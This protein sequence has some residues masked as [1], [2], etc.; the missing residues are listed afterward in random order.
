MVPNWSP[1]PFVSLKAVSGKQ[2][3]P[4]AALPERTSSTLKS[5]Q[6]EKERRPVCSSSDFV[7]QIFNN[8]HFQHYATGKPTMTFRQ[9][10]FLYRYQRVKYLDECIQVKQ[11]TELFVS[12]TKYF[13]PSKIKGKISEFTG[14]NRPQIWLVAKVYSLC[15]LKPLDQKQKRPRLF[16]TFDLFQNSLQHS[17]TG[18]II[19]RDRFGCRNN[20][21]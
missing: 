3:I 6:P 21:S 8:F 20:K 1:G 7:H 2:I 19:F 12:Q 4:S 16:G 10:V 17:I 13:C 14:I 15:N 5:R 11:V 18:K 9:N